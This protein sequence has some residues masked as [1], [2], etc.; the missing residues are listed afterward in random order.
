MT[1]TRRLY[2][3]IPTVV[4]Y[5]GNVKEKKTLCSGNEID[6]YNMGTLLHG[7]IIYK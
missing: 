7:Y 4:L 1:R 2:N 5:S 6:S 3:Y